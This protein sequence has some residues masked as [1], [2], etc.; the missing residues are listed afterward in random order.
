[1]RTLSAKNFDE[2]YEFILH[3]FNVDGVEVDV[4]EWQAIRDERPQTKTIEIQDISFEMPIT[5]GLINDVDPNMPWAEDHFQERVSGIPYNPPPSSDWWPFAQKSNAEH[6]TD[7]KFSHTYPERF[8]ASK[9]DGTSGIR[10]DF[11][12]LGD[13]IEILRSRPG[14]RQ[15]YL[16]VW[17]PEDLLESR[18]G[19]RVPCTLGYHF[20]IRNGKLKVVYYIRSCDFYRH[21]RDDV[22]MAARLG[23]WVAEQVGVTADKLVMHISSMHVFSVEK[24]KLEYDYSHSLLGRLSG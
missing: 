7:E 9:I 15:A 17:F 11:G 2:V 4:G 22:Y 23:Q 18:L 21:F 24:A 8:W 1:M 6:K 19:E 12:D 10:G 13:L 14:T 3:V 16:P 20:L 5:D